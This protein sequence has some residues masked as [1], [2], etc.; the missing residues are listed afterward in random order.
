MNPTPP[1]DSLFDDLGPLSPSDWAES[2]H[3]PADAGHYDELRGRS[4][5]IEGML[6]PHWERFFEHVGM[7]GLADLSRRQD[8]LNR[9]LRDNGVT[10]NVYAE[11]TGEQRPWSL[12]LLPMILS[13]EDWA[14]IEAGTLQRARLLNA[15]MG[16]IY[17]ERQLLKKA[18]LPPALVLGHSGYLRA[19]QG[20]DAPGQTWLP[21]VAFDL[22]RG[23][24]GRWWVV[25]QRTQAPS[26]LGYLLENRIAVSRQFPRAFA[27]LRIQ[28]LAASYRDFLGALRSLTPQGPDAHVALLTPGPYNETY[29]EQAY[30]AQYLGVSLVEGNDLTVRDQRLFLKTLK[31]LEPVHALIK[32]VDDA[33]VD[34]LTFRADSALGVPGIVGVLRA[35][36]LAMA[37][38]PGS[39]PLESSAILG[40]LPG[41]CDHL[42]G[43]SL[44]LPSLAT[45]WCGEEASLNSVLPQLRKGVI[46]NTYPDRDNAAVM[47]RRL[48]PQQ[49]DEWTGRMVRSPDNYTVQEWLP[50]P[51]TPT[52]TDA[53]LVPRSAMLRVF[54]LCRGPGQWQILPGGMVRIARRGQ[55]IATMQRGGSSAD[56]WVMTE[57]P[58]DH[59]NMPATMTST[60]EVASSQRVVTS[61]VAENLFWL[62]RYTERAENSIRLARVLLEQLASEEASSEALLLWMDAT[63]REASLVLPDVPS[64]IASPRVF[65]RALVANLCPPGGQPHADLSMSVGSQLRSLKAAASQVRDRLSAEHWH[66]IARCEAG[67]A[68]DL[69]GIDSDSSFAI[70][71]AIEA[72]QNASELLAAITGSQTDRM[73]RD[74]GW[75]LLSIGRHIERILCL[76]QSMRHA[77]ASQSIQDAAGFDALV[78]QFDSTITFHAQFQQRRDI[79]ALVSLLVLDPDNPR[80]LAWVVRTL[81]T[82]LGKLANS[83]SVQDSTLGQNLPQ[84]SSWE[85]P[86]LCNWERQPDG[87]RVWRALMEVIEQC[88]ASAWSLSESI[89][90]LHFSHAD[91]RLKSL[92]A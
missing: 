31:G 46:R 12:D 91:N 55:L 77:L 19:M 36:N 56:C 43:E 64:A 13:T 2:V 39:S 20:I 16:D 17:G 11:T 89:S 92:G 61:R 28:R 74:D 9:Q 37:N 62:G 69:D 26:G 87:Q 76:S 57:G 86:E 1:P 60:M 88:E 34:P 18:L 54:A 45:W 90:A 21:I 47:G 40:F 4:Q 53:Q 65:A 14:Q 8:N 63:A 7:D 84:P 83:E 67:F 23:P 72:L 42:L 6:A 33:W 3:V 48:T 85:L 80:S 73:V 68:G 52:W 58:V 25:S 81:R 79:V 71:E 51:Q 30:L 44:L 22:A 66:L 29:F 27:G 49:I 75:R 82:R 38:M 15:M 41:V 78:A 5:G 59:T 35:G 24:D 10:Y 32:R 70:N 50:L